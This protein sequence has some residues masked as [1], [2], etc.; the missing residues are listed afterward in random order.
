VSYFISLLVY[1][2]A[3]SVFKSEHRE[4]DNWKLLKIEL[5]RSCKETVVA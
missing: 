5:G 1:L 2:M 3:F 4:S